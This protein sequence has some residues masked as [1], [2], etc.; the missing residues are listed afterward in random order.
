MVLRKL[1]ILLHLIQE[2]EGG[3]LTYNPKRVYALENGYSQ[4]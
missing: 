2:S 3:Q 4:S 1:N